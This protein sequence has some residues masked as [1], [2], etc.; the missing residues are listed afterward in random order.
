M[1]RT[2]YDSVAYDKIPKHA[3][4]VAGYVDG[5]YK[6]PKKAWNLFP[7][8]VHVRI[9]VFH[10]TLDAEVLDIE[11]GNA[12]PEEGVSWVKQRRS[13]GFDPSVYC[14]L[15]TYP[16]VRKAFLAAGEDMPHVWL[17]HWDDE[18]LI[19]HKAIAKQYHHN[20][21]YDTSIVADHW[22]GIDPKLKTTETITITEEQRQA[23]KAVYVFLKTLFG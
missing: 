13:Q 2:M 18:P 9:A 5:L 6:W 1:T 22:P 10:T 3:Q 11:K 20:P 16:E 14:N 7:N 4:M 23:L 12:T 19:P 21:D 15:N 8:A 17:A